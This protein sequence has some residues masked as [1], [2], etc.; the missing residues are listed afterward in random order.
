MKHARM[1]AVAALILGGLP[2]TAGAWP[3]AASDAAAIADHIFS[4]A[5]S[6]KDGA[7]TSEEYA[8]GGLGKYG[9]SFGDFDLDRDGR[10]TLAEYREVFARFHSG[11]RQDAI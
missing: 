11:V 6:D 5:D 8:S 10:V 7:M 2:L 1:A 4:H 9:A 3:D